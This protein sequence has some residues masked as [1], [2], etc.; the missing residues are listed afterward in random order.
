[1]CAILIINLGEVGKLENEKKNKYN[2]E[3]P[4]KLGNG[5]K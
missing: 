3:K 5:S 2:S 4:E 1:M